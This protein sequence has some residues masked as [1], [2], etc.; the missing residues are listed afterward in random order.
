[1]VLLALTAVLFPLQY[2][3]LELPKRIINDAID[4][5]QSFIDVFDYEMTQETFLIVLSC[6]FLL[7]VLGHGLMKMRINTM[8]GILSER[9]LR[10]YRFTLIAQIMRFPQP[11]L[12]RTSQGEMVSMVTAEAEPMGGMMGDA[13]SLPVMQAGQMITIL[14]FL[15]LQNLWF[16]LAAIALIPFQAWLIPKLQRRINLLNKDRI[17][18]VRHLAAEI[19]ETATGAP[20]LRVNGGWRYRLSMVTRRLGTL[21]LIRLSIYQKKFFMKFLNNFITQLTPFFFYLV[22]GLLV[23]RGQVSLG[24]LVAALAAYKDLSSP[25]KELLN[26]YNRVA[27]LSLRWHLIGD[28]FTPPGLIDEDLMEGG[29]EVVQRL[30]GDVVLKDI[31][32]RDHDGD[33]VL[34]NI[35]ATL[36]QGTIVGVRSQD[37]EERRAVAELFTR[38]ILPTSGTLEIGGAKIKDLH[39]RVIST[40]IGYADPSP[41]VFQGTVGGNVW[42]PLQRR[43]LANLPD[44]MGEAEEKKRAYESKRTGNS[45]DRFY[46]NWVDP[47]LADME[48]EDE[49]HAW[50]VQLM[51][52]TGAGNALFRRGLDQPF[53]ESDHAE[54]AQTLVDL[55]PEITAALAEA[56][57]AKAYYRFDPDL[58]NPALPVA[59]NLFFAT[60]RRSVEEAGEGNTGDFLNLLH[61]LG[62]EDGIL[63]MSREVIEMLNQTFGVDGTDHP[64]FRQLGLNPAAFTKK[65]ELVSKSRDVGLKNMERKELEQMLELPFEVSAERIGPGFSDEL[66]E[67]IL[68]LRHNEAEKLSEWL[69]VYFAPLREDRFAPGLTVLENAI[70]GKLSASAGPRSEQV[71][72]IVAQKLREAGMKQ[73]VAELLF[74]VRTGIGGAGLPAAFLEPLAISRAAIKKPDMLI[75]NRCLASYEEGQAAETIANLKALLPN[76]TLIFLEDDFED[77]SSFDMMLELEHGRLKDSDAGEVEITDN[78]AS[79]DLRKKMRALTST[80]MFA[81]LSRR[82]IRLLAFGAQWHEAKA[83]EHVFRMGDDPAD[84]AYLILQGEA[85]LGYQDAAGATQVVATAGAGTLVG[86][87]ALI[88][89]EKRAL[90]MYAKSDLE[91]LRLGESEFMAVVENDASTAFRI[92]QAVSGYVGAPKQ[93]RTESDDTNS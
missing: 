16:G 20:A 71:R 70:Y 9:M 7:A 28:R 50:W 93:S 21:F 31:F 49:V 8:K 44:P 66:K 53:T 24:A 57:L 82:Q 6:L 35:S 43:P 64:L 25:W 3:T 78:A 58:Y 68:S 10:R 26:Y 88:R 38:E 74:A 77:A 13:I 63:R 40:R 69:V 22:G 11:Y 84:G 67:S 55:R 33:S 41:Y 5:E 56:G 73:E 34:E 32:V 81:G 52:A 36:P 17:Q 76:T 2:L 1:M 86:E 14:S 42:M 79:A 27:D 72:D 46:A 87:L 39:Q 90:D 47:T 60:P 91:T 54:L 18:E 83:G 75:L 80:D 4:A 48:D 23:I 19:G 45:E 12:R 62:I 61:D 29:P 65:V 89:K 30:P 59:A 92:L 37:A 15:F 51:D 85:D